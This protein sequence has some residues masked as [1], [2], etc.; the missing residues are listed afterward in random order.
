[1]VKGSEMFS[2]LK[3]SQPLSISSVS[4][5]GFR[6]GFVVFV[7]AVKIGTGE[8]RLDELDCKSSSS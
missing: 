8:T 3:G 7:S 6:A 5:A 4:S 1:M 2:N